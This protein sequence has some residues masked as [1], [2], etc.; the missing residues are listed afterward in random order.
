MPWG[1]KRQVNN[2][3]RQLIVRL[4]KQDQPKYRMNIVFRVYDDGIGFRYEFP[5][6]P[7]LDTVYI[8]EEHSAFAL[9]G[10]HTCY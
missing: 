1:E 7:G 6:Q 4:A 10:D 3:Y 2:N 8:M 5:Q 9:T